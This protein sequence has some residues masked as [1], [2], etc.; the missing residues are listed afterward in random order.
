MDIKFVTAIYSKLHGTKFN[1]SADAI[2][3][4]YRQSL[5][6]IAKGGYEIICYT[7]DIHFEELTEFYKEYPNIKVVQES[8][9]DFYFHDQI[10]KIKELKPNY[11]TDTSWYTRC[12]EIM[13]GKFYW[14]LRHAGMLEENDHIFWID[15]GIFH[16][17][18]IHGKWKSDKSDNFFDFDR[19]TQER[20]LYED[21]SN[22]AGDKILNII[23]KQV[24]HGSDD[25][26]SLLG[27]EFPRPQYGIIG[28]IFGGRRDLILDYASKAIELMQKTIDANLLLKEEEI[29]H[30][31]HFQNPEEF[32]T[33]TFGTWYH[34]DWDAAYRRG[35]S[36]S[37]SD[38]FTFLRTLN[39]S[40]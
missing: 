9:T 15:A 39:N 31:L 38:Y 32:S 25:Y 24:N 13:W 11:N 3:E 28:G 1:G 5:R 40:K 17:G 2:F 19:I 14:L 26:I 22:H 23:S 37:F 30:Y 4:R 18:L 8:L 36:V 35:E 7:S 27:T 16:S 20:N 34:E 21:L 10:N 12:V 6:S 29:M 33:F